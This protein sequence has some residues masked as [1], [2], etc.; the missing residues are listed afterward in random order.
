MAC[1]TDGMNSR[2]MRPPA[3]S[4]DELHAACPARQRL[5]H[6]LDFGELARTARLLL[7]RVD[8][9]DGPAEGF[10]EADLG[11][12][13]VGFDAELGAH[14]VDGDFEVQL[15]HAAQH[16]LAGFLVHF[17]PQRRVG[18]DHLVERGRHLV[19]VGAGLRLD[20][21]ADD[22]VREAH[23]LEQR[24]MVRIAQRIAGLGVLHRDEGAD[25]AG[26]GFVDVLG[27]V[28]LHLDDAAD[29]LLLAA[30]HVE[31]RVAL[32]DHA[33]IDAHEGQRAELVV[34][35]LEG[36]GARRCVVAALP[37]RR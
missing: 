14:A 23:A 15:A 33:R 37:A 30:R 24:R 29:A 13:H 8:A 18:L 26:A 7:V 16:G 9:L 12:A 25:V 11:L 6:H 1:S 3:T 17:Q 4:S 19:D 20:G 5:E 32:L 36:Q 31:Q 2:G 35:H 34:D 27:D 28:G 10:A 22:G 21:H